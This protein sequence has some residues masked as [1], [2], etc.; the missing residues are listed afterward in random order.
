MDCLHDL[1]R[2]AQTSDVHALLKG[3]DLLN[4]AEQ[5]LT[6]NINPSLVMEQTVMGLWHI[7]RAS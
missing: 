2:Y 7:I 1:E 5:D 3:I 6:D 4:R